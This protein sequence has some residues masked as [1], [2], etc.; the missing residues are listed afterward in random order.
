L[1]IEFELPLFGER[2]CLNQF[3]VEHTQ[4]GSAALGKKNIFNFLNLLK[5]L[6]FEKNP[7]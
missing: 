3:Q 5:S 7:E 1:G 6:K 2:D 4:V